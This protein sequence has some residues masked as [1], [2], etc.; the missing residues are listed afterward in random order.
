MKHLFAPVDSLRRNVL[1]IEDPIEYRLRSTT[2]VAVNE[3]TGLSFSVAL[4]AFLR[5]QKDTVSETWTYLH[6]TH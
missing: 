5:H 6:P 4:R 3:D 1:T 2:Q